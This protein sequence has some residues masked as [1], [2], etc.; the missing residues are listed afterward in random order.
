MDEYNRGKAMIKYQYIL[1]EEKKRYYVPRA[2]SMCEARERD[3]LFEKYLSVSPLIVNPRTWELLLK[4]NKV[5][6][7]EV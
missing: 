5:K 3:A 4:E 2:P 1:L 6:Y 7:L